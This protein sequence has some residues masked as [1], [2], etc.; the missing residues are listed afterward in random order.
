[1]RHATGAEVCAAPFR[2]VRLPNFISDREF[3]A[4]LITELQS[5]DMQDKNNDLYKFKQSIELKH[6]NSPCIKSLRQ[7]FQ[8]QLLP[9]LRDVTESPLND[10]VDLFC[11]QYDYTDTLLCHDDELEERHIAF[12]YYLVP[13]SWSSEDGGTLD[14]F[15][16]DDHCQPTDIVKSI[17]PTQNQFVFFEVSPK[18]FHQVSE[19]LS[20]EKTRLAVSGWFHGP[21]ITRPSPYCDPPPPVL[22]YSTVEED[23]FFNWIN[24]IYLS[25]EIQ[26][27]IRERFEAESEIEL[28]DFLKEEKYEELVAA[29][30]GKSVPW[31]HRGPANKRSYDVCARD[32]LP[33]EAQ[34]LMEIM[35]SDA[36]FLLLSQMTG[37]QLHEMA[38]PSDEESTENGSELN[39][40]AA[41]SVSSRCRLEAQKWKHGD[42]T[43]VH[44]TDAQVNE[45][46][47]D[48]ALFVGGS[49]WNLDIGGY[50]S[51][52]AKGEDEELLSVCP[53]PNSLALVYREEETMRFVKHINHRATKAKESQYYTVSA[54]YY[55][56]PE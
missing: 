22:S 12:I 30:T 31:T 35:Q 18:S 39:G 7:V 19:V 32:S 24:P 56:K 36:M 54:I 37:L 3:V 52:I 50:I 17:V 21:P 26:A 14:L 29:M 47:L 1:M 45:V 5:L 23:V 42:Y 11:S 41:R 25:P 48:S 2:H 51:Y 8:E 34:T 43:L 49:E 15:D 9:W 33:P 44:D 16:T 40:D 27:D 38:P 28:S 55:E 13:Q 4:D 53:S 46:A 10:K 20:E 6:V